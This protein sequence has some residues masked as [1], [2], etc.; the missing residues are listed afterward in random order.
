MSPQARTP[1]TWA[2]TDRVRDA[3]TGYGTPLLLFSEEKIRQG[4]RDVVKAFSGSENDRVRFRIL[5]SVK[6]NPLASIVRLLVE[7]GA[8]FECSDFTEVRLLERVG[9]SASSCVLTSLWKSEQEVNRALKAKVAALAIDSV[10]DVVTISNVAESVGVRAPALLRVNSGIVARGTRFH[11]AGP[12]SKAGA[13]LDTDVNNGEDAGS[14]ITA[15]KNSPGLELRGIHGHLG[16]QVVR[17]ADFDAHVSRLARYIREAERAYGRE[18]SLLDVGGGFPVDYGRGRVPSVDAVAATIQRALAKEG[19]EGEALIEPGRS[20]TANGGVLVTRVAKV[21]RSPQG[22][23]VAVLDAS[24]YNVLLDSLVAGWRYPVRVMRRSDFEEQR[25][26]DLAP[27][28]LAGATND[29]LDVFGRLESS[30]S[31]RYKKLET[32]DYVLFERVGAYSVSFNMNYALLPA[33]PCL[34]VKPDGEIIEIRRRESDEEVL[35]RFGA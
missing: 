25:V 31:Q 11:S 21:R 27:T 20:I 10:T 18:L 26:E 6:N 24:A 2:S 29:T 30:S 17:L 32:G 1:V 35:A 16:S 14:V 8:W 7:E 3:V 5:F 9:A 12:T 28:L 22:D 33:P 34:L 13:W 19:F 15:L 23:H 4:Y